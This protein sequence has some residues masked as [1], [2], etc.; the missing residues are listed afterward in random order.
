MPTRDGSEFVISQNVLTYDSE[1]TE[2]VISQ[3]VLTY[4]Y[5]PASEYVQLYM[6]VRTCTCTCTCTG[7]V[8]VCTCTCTAVHVR[9]YGLQTH[10]RNSLVQYNCCSSENADSN[11]ASFLIKANF[12]VPSFNII[13]AAQKMLMTTEHATARER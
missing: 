9:K 1:F 12:S 4:V 11:R 10:V 2:F 3:N 13:V 8:D 6:Y 7:T 5:V